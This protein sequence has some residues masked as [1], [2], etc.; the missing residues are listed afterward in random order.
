MRRASARR[1]RI[2]ERVRPEHRV[3]VEER[4]AWPMKTA[5]VTGRDAS[6][7]TWRSCAT[8]SQERSER[9]RPSSPV[10]QNA[11]PSAHPAWDEAHRV[12]RVEE[13]DP[14]RLDPRAVLELEQVAAEAVLGVGGRDAA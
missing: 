6:A 14:H 11:Q 4:L 13:R 2:T 12:V 8:I 1:R 9:T 10:A 3:V 5:P 7:R